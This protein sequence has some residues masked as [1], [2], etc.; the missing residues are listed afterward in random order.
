M[1]LAAAGCPFRLDPPHDTVHRSLRFAFASHEQLSWLPEE[2]AIERG[3]IN[4]V[5]CE[6]DL[7]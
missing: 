7:E 3:G 2:I 4:A 5:P 1:I 6:E